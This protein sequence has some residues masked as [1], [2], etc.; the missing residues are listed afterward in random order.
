MRTQQ[1]EEYEREVAELRLLLEAKEI[2]YE[3]LK[4]IYAEAVQIQSRG[5]D[6][7]EGMERSLAVGAGCFDADTK[8]INV[9]E[10]RQSN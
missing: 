4:D 1:I 6:L 3:K 8:Y 5:R 10:S 9:E 2:K 7:Y